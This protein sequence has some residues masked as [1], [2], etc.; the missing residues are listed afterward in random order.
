[1]NIINQIEPTLES[2]AK[3]PLL[4]KVT[5]LIL[6]ILAVALVLSGLLAFLGGIAAIIEIIP[7]NLAHGLGITISLVLMI[8]AV[9]L[10]VRILL[11]RAR[12]IL[13]CGENDYPVIHLS[14]IL[15]RGCGE[16]LALCWTTLGLTAGILIWFSGTYSLQGIPFPV[17]FAQGPAFIAGLAAVLS[18][19]VM[20]VFI[21]IFFY[22]L[23]ELLLLLRKLARG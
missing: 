16:L 23:A 15:L 10:A 5:A 9:F 6:R 7:Y 1:M 21:L 14:S 22:L 20:G 8:L 11:F 12:S 4:R 2:L 17:I 13:I 3:G 19:L 18:A